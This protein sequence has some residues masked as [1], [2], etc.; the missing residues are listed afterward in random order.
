VCWIAA[1]SI[2][3]E[4]VDVE[5]AKRSNQRIIGKPVCPIREARSADFLVE[6]TIASLVAASDPIPTPTRNLNDLAPEAIS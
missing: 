4:V 5:V 2:A 3:A 6:N 1:G